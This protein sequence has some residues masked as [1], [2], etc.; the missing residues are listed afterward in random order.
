MDFIKAGQ[1]LDFQI[2]LSKN[3]FNIPTACGETIWE[4]PTAKR[5]KRT[6]YDV[7]AKYWSHTE[8]FSSSYNQYLAETDR[9]KIIIHKIYTVEINKTAKRIKRN[10]Y[11]TQ[12][13]YWSHTENF[14]SMYNQYLAEM[15]TN[16]KC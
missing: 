12:A 14:N 10:E 16:V 5:I 3:A 1:K 8:N 6:E 13:K 4:K 2:N 9:N 7:Q 11:D 15:K